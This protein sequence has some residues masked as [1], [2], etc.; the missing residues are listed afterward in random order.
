MREQATELRGFEVLAPLDLL[1]KF[2][3]TL[4]LEVGASNTVDH[5][6]ALIFRPLPS[7]PWLMHILAGVH[8]QTGPD[9]TSWAEH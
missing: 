5:N 3:Q 2:H 7:H 8:W 1:S 4:R 9:G 6:V